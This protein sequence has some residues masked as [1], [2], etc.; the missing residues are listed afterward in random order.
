MGFI[1]HSRTNGGNNIEN[2]TIVDVRVDDV[3]TF[4]INKRNWSDFQQED[5][6][7]TE[8][9]LKDLKNSADSWRAQAS[10]LLT[11]GSKWIIGSSVWVVEDRDPDLWTKDTTQHTSIFVALQ[12][13]VLLRSASLAH[14]QYAN[15]LAVTKDRGLVLVRHHSR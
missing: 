2:R 13:L 8:V 7:G 11:V 9:N 5:F 6:K 4:E 1:A 3:L 10:D 15:H 12:F 14:A